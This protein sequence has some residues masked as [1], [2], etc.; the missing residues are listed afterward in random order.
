MATSLQKDF[1]LILVCVLL[2]GVFRVFEIGY[3]RGHMAPHVRMGDF[4]AAI[5]NGARFDSVI[6]GYTGILSVLISLACGVFPLQ[7]FADRFRMVIAFVFVWLSG[8]LFVANLIFIAEFKDNFNLLIFNIVYDDTVA[9]LQ[10][11]WA[12]LSAI[13][14]C[15]GSG[16]RGRASQLGRAPFPEAAVF[17]RYAGAFSSKPFLAKRGC[18]SFADRGFCRRDPRIG[19][20]Q[21]GSIQGCRHHT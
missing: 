3:F 10:S 4:L 12:G 8:A 18:R 21:A 11:A 17:R 13:D 15:N 16:C 1:K 14:L 9:I 2:L 7:R 6:A 19:R 20:G 5:A